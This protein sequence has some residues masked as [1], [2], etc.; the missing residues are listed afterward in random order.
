MQIE[1]EGGF[2][3]FNERDE[4][5]KTEISSESCLVCNNDIA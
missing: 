5:S 3:Q 1:G 2:Y 4:L